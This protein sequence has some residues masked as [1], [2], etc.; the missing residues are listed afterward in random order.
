MAASSRP[1]MTCATPSGPSSPATTPSGW[2]RRTGTAAPPRYVLPGRRRP[3]GGPHKATHCPDS[4]VRYSGAVLVERARVLAARVSP[5]R[6]PGLRHLLGG[7][8]ATDPSL[9]PLPAEPP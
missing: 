8:L 4:R 6:S 5:G 7:L 2:L 1:L 3:S 9:P